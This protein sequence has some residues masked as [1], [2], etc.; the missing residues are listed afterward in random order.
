MDISKSVARACES[1]RAF[2]AKVIDSIDAVGDHIDLILKTAEITVISILVKACSKTTLAL[3][4]RA[5]YV[6]E[7]IEEDERSRH[8]DYRR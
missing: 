3:A 8:G 4:N 6:A 5:R 2:A 1:G 7:C